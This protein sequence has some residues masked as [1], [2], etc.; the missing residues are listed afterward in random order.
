MWRVSCVIC[1]R[2]SCADTSTHSHGR[3]SVLWLSMTSTAHRTS[4]VRVIMA[5]S[6]H[7]FH[8]RLHH[9]LL[10]GQQLE[11]A[12]VSLMARRT[13]PQALQ[14]ATP[15][16]HTGNALLCQLVDG[17][18]SSSTPRLVDV[19]KVWAP[20]CAPPQNEL[21]R[22]FNTGNAGAWPSPLKTC[23][24]RHGRKMM[25]WTTPRTLL[26]RLCPNK[27]KTSRRLCPF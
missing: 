13:I 7:P 11:H 10:T 24:E 18:L 5:T 8:L 4:F 1:F 17:A 27:V 15:G 6:T 20:F 23:K 16:E 19:G 26:C 22:T 3:S 2:Q 21:A 9:R 25:V 12:A 14:T